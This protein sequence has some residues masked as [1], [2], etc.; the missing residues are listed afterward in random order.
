MEY[1]RLGRSG[2]KVGV[3]A[4]GTWVTFTETN[5]PDAIVANLRVAREGGVN[6]F[7]TA[8][9]Y[10]QGLAEERL[11]E[12]LR[13]LAWPRGSYVLATKLYSGVHSWVNMHHTLNR[14]Y[15]MQAIDESLHRLRTPFVDLLFCHRPDPHTPLEEVV[16]A[17]SD[18]VGAGKAHYWGTS[19]W[20]AEEIRAAWAI[21]DR[22]GLRKPTMEQPEYNLFNRTRVEGDYTALCQELG[23]GLTTWSPLASGVLSGKYRTGVPRDSRATRP[24]FRWL[25]PQL[26][27]ADRN[28]RVEKL[29]GLAR[30]IGAT[31]AQLA[32]A[33]CA[34]NSVVSSVIMG[35]R[36]P[37]QLLENLAALDIVPLLTPDFLSR[38][39]AIME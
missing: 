3:L 7:D 13:V 25:E 1:R 10:G 4:Y 32:I 18:I 8:D 11:G 17:M 20:P 29:G 24:G 35:A 16:W 21:A 2:L 27:D 15:L 36:N 14:K 19:E 38:I 39:A 33:W 6:L 34:R 26:V 23:L 12:A 22:Y 9:G 30:A 31:T 37:D 5:D 28:R